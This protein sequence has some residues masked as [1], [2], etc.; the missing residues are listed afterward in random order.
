MKAA[1]AMAATIWLGT[2]A[3]AGAQEVRLGAAAP[4][5]IYHGWGIFGAYW[6]TS[7][8]GSTGGAGGRLSIEMVSGVNLELRGTAFGR[9]TAGEERVRVTPWDVGL[10]LILPVSDLANVTA[11]GGLTFASVS[12]AGARSETGF[13]GSLGVDVAI[14]PQARLFA[15]AIYRFLDVDTRTQ[16]IELDGIGIQGGVLITW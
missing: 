15:D 14:R 12:G 11:G 3:V 4:D 16:D 10:S 5:H 1:W 9:V 2:L 6:N 8:G 13:Y 7:D